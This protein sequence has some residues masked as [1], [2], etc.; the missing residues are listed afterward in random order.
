MN[1]DHVHFYVEDAAYWQTWF[2]QKFGFQTLA[3]QLCEHTYRVLVGAQQIRFW[4]SSPRSADSP[5]ATYL[6]AHPAGVVDLA[7]RVNDLDAVLRQAERSSIPIWQLPRIVQ[8]AQGTYRMAQIQGWDDLRHT[9]IEGLDSAS[10]AGMPLTSGLSGYSAF[11]PSF[12]EPIAASQVLGPRVAGEIDRTGSSW[13]GIDHVVLNVMSGDLEKA[14]HRYETLFGFRRQQNFAIQTERSA[15]CSQV[16]SHPDGPMQLPINQPASPDSQIQEFLDWNRGSGVQ[17]I[18][19]R[20]QNI[21]D[22]MPQLRDQ[23]IAFLTVPPSYY[24]QLH[25]RSGFALTTAESQAIAAQQV[26]VD[27]QPHQP[28]ALLLQAFTQPIFEQPTFFFELIERRSYRV[29]QQLQTVQGFGERNFQ[30]LFEAI[31]RE[32]M[33]RGSLKV[34]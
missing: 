25:Q 8:S 20:T 10:T 11:E 2:V 17:H 28:Q 32:Q 9:L 5:V 27:W 14:I 7:F 33:K 6:A 15:L 12:L 3:Y 21:L 19:L 4:L 24:E 29:S 23:G 16:L 1:L 34:E 13:V 18:A 31:E 22:L 26:L 30:A